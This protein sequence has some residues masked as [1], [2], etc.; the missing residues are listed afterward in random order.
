[1]TGV[2]VCPPIR[3][4]KL[5]YSTTRPHIQPLVSPRCCTQC[6]RYEPGAGK[7]TRRRGTRRT[8]Y[9]Q[10]AGQRVPRSEADVSFYLP[11]CTDSAP[12]STRARD[13]AGPLAPRSRRP[14][15]GKVERAQEASQPTLVL[16]APTNRPAHQ[17]TSSLPTDRPHKQAS[18]INLRLQQLQDKETCPLRSCPRPGRASS[19]ICST[20]LLPLILPRASAASTAAPEFSFCRSTRHCGSHVS[21][22][23]VILLLLL[24][25]PPTLLI[26]CFCLLVRPT[27][28]R[29]RHTTGIS[30]AIGPPACSPLSYLPASPLQH[31][32]TGHVPSFQSR[33][34]Y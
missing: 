30:R 24:R 9:D 23:L 15:V 13:P 33:R 21:R 8:E 20:N 10:Q 34:K 4:A 28:R 2:A 1:M 26:L 32:S 29:Q 27:I 14:K 31:S 12:T 7:R 19:S 25:L 5:Q 6:S 22:S 3:R 18:V 11:S 16:P 17:N